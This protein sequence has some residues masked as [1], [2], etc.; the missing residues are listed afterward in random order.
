MPTNTNW[1]IQDCEACTLKHTN[2]FK[3][4]TESFVVQFEF[5]PTENGY[6]VYYPPQ[7]HPDYEEEGYEGWG[8]TPQQALLQLVEYWNN[9]NCDFAFPFTVVSKE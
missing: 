9:N 8:L 4:R 1:C 5:E 6:Y 7:N 2:K 3:T